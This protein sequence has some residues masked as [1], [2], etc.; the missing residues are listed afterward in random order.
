[1]PSINPILNLFGSSP[2]KPLQQHMAKVV[3]CVNEL[4]ALIEAAC[5]DD[6]TKVAAQRERIA[7]LENEADDLKHAL[8]LHLPRSL[9]LPV[10][11]RD[12]LEVLTTQDSVANCAKDIAGLVRGRRMHFPDVIGSR[13]IKFTQRGVDACRQAEKTVNELDE[14]VQTGFR[15]AE[16][17]LVE[18]MIHDLDHI[19]KDTDVLQI[20]VRDALLAVEKDL[21]PVDVIFFYRII[22]A[23][24]NLADRAQRVGSRLQLML[25]R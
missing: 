7:A 14:L 13:L 9:F 10:D 4:P 22:G 19:E 17:K 23:I 3:E 2:V 24:G 15:G 20:E 11:R 1:V 21:P 16:V 12:V 6:Q 25:A 8:R 5:V 18:N